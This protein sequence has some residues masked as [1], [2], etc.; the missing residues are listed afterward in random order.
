M[1]EQ[2]T[3]FVDLRST[4]DQLRSELDG[5][6]IKFGDETE[7]LETAKAQCDGASVAGDTVDECV[8]W[9]VLTMRS[10][11]K[12]RKAPWHNGAVWM[13]GTV[14]PRYAMKFSE[15]EIE[16][17]AYYLLSVQDTDPLD[18]PKDNQ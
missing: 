2:L 12:A 10:P 17:M 6:W 8:D 15:E 7:Q 13:S 9:L 14:K 16:D 1:N 5:V 11:T 3:P 4:H 18:I